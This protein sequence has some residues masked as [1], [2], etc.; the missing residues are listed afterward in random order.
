MHPVYIDALL[1][2]SY[3]ND[4]KM[5]VCVCVCVKY[6]YKNELNHELFNIFYCAVK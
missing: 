2:L 5:C 6:K 4:V 1:K 3:A